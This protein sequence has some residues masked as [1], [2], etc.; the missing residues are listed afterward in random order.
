MNINEFTALLRALFRNEKGRPYPIDD[1]ICTEIFNIFNKSGVRLM[2]MLSTGQKTRKIQE[3]LF[4]IYAAFVRMADFP[5]HCF[6]NTCKYYLICEVD[7]CK[8]SS[9][10]FSFSAQDG[11]L[12]KTEFAFC[13]N[14]WIK[15]VVR[16]IS[17]LL[18]VDVQNDFISGSLAISNCPAQHNG[19]EVS[20]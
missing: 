19:E 3:H 14:N 7:F 13:W 1:Q 20:E 2:I 4:A 6:K 16:P 9:C 15:K 8:S 10:I 17:A 12:D 18:I 5:I 11:S